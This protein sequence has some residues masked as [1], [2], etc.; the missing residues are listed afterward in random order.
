MQ[1]LVVVA[2]IQM[3]ALKTEVEKGFMRTVVGHGLV[4]PKRQGCSA[5]AGFASYLERACRGMYSQITRRFRI[6][7]F[8]GQVFKDTN[9]ILQGC[10]LSVTLLNALMAVLSCALEPTL[11]AES[12]VDD[13]TILHSSENVLQSGMDAIDKFM[14]ATG[15]VVNLKKTKG[16][17]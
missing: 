1:I 11:T 16:V 8:I 17:G 4:D 14:Q 13:L 9:G 6:G 10:P 12:F 15:Q 3:R 7:G 2:N 5:H